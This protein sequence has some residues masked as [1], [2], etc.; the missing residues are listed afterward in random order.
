MGNERKN[1]LLVSIVEFA[2]LFQG[3]LKRIIKRDWWS[4]IFERNRKLATSEND[5]LTSLFFV[6]A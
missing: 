4:H 3:D 6:V 2:C 1:K 5:R